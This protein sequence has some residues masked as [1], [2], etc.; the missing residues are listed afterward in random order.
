MF[1]SGLGLLGCVAALTTPPVSYA[2]AP[3]C[4]LVIA[5]GAL[6]DGT[7][8][9]YAAFI[10]SL[11]GDGPIVIVPSASGEPYQSTQ[12][13]VERFTRYGVPVERIV[14]A[15]L[16]QVD[17]PE[18]P[19]RDESRW[20]LNGADPELVEIL[21][22]ASGIW[23]TGGDQARTTA[24]LMPEGQETPTLKA[25]RSACARGAVIGGTSAGAAIMSDPM[26]TGGESLAALL[27]E[28]D[29]DRGA[30]TLAAGLGFFPDMLVDQHFDARVRLGRLVVALSQ[31]PD[32][33]TRVGFGIDEN[34]ALWV[35]K[36]GS[37]MVLG[38]G[39]VTLIDAR[40][41]TFA[42]AP[43]RA[44]HI[45]GLVV[46]VLSRGDTIL[47][48]S[49]EVNTAPYRKATVGREYVDQ[50]LPGGGGMAVATPRL[51]N[52]LGEGLVDNAAARVLDRLSF[53]DKGR[54]ILF[55]FT[56]TPQS[57]GAWGRDENGV[58]NYTINN[59]GFDILPAETFGK[60]ENDEPS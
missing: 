1:R 58:G 38:A 59:V 10:A 4:P 31:Q 23:F 30:V 40:Q 52:L 15:K 16:A 47:I 27:G 60:A 49:L 44:A 32:P 35:R 53:D 5:G 3:L 22:D 21:Q 54:A 55:R 41:S 50:P 24:L 39:Q 42:M 33:Q 34:T 13:M 36:D 2:S 17:D 29:P 43:N 19:D 51:A 45:T 48:A 56:Q 9:V 8:D 14:G 6:E 37:A 28:T 46:S 12:A 11:E 18:T 7:A 57:T 20:A 25:I 26:L